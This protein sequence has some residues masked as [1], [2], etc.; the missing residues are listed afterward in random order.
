MTRAAITMKGKC[1]RIC[2]VLVIDDLEY[3]GAQRQV[4][5]LANNMDPDR[6]DVHVCALSDYVP[7]GGQV[8]DS[9]RR[10]H[11]LP[12]K[13]KADVTVVPR[14]ARLLRSLRR[15]RPQLFVQ[16]GHRLSAGGTPRGHE[17]GGRVRAKCKLLPR[18]ETEARLPI[19]APLCRSYDCQ[20]ACRR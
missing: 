4:V 8:R 12:K 11:I 9:E 18:V 3:G 19:D 13:N 16:C 17:V 7:L 1:T 14:L 20:F 2:V 5:E 10:L 15:C 6:F